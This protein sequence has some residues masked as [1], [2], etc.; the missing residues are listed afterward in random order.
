[1]SVAP[2]CPASGIDPNCLL[3]Q[4]PIPTP[5]PLLT[6]PPTPTSPFSPTPYPPP[7]SFTADSSKFALPA[8]TP[9]TLTEHVPCRFELRLKF[10]KHEI[11]SWIR[12]HMPNYLSTAAPYSLGME[13]VLWT[14]TGMLL[15]FHA[16]TKVKIR[17][18]PPPLP[19]PPPLLPHQTPTD[20]NSPTPLQPHT[21][22]PVFTHNSA[23]SQLFNNPY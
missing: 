19:P 8:C 22:Y 16:E 17:C 4:S 13:K 7:T 20:P 23:V 15:L 14:H 1:M 2:P 5:S 21:H 3:P 9:G 11:T 18:F 6:Q 10:Y 12:N